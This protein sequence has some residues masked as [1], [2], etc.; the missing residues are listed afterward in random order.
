[1]AFR[2]KISESLVYN[3]DPLDR[4]RE[5]TPRQIVQQEIANQRILLD[6]NVS[7]GSWWD[8]ENDC[9]TVHVRD[10]SFFN[11][12]GDYQNSGRLYGSEFLNEAWSV[13][14][15]KK[16]IN[17][18]ETALQ[19]DELTQDTDHWALVYNHSF[20]RLLISLWMERVQAAREDRHNLHRSFL[21]LLR[22]VD[23]LEE[24]ADK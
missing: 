22:R 19:N 12:G 10:Y 17:E 9:V 3:A 21:K 20:T 23:A 1:M 24:T 8:R 15:V 4:R 7:T 6:R 18:F 2:D 16:F 5:P 14:T 11:E 13:P